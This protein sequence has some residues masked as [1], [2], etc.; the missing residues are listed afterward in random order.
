MNKET[1]G[2]YAF[3]VGLVISVIAGFVS[4]GTMGLGALVV[5]GLIVGFLNVTGA[6]VQKF[7]LGTVALMLVG[8]GLHSVMATV[9]LVPDILAAFVSFVAGAALIVALKEVYTI[10]KSK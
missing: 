3:I 6:E 10:T 9:P 4:L 1:I 7:L 5:L 8:Q 2:R